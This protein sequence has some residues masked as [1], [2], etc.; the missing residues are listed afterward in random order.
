MKR[1]IFFNIV[2]FKKIKKVIKKCFKYCSNPNYIKSQKRLSTISFLIFFFKLTIIILIA[3]AIPTVLNSLNLIPTNSIS[4]YNV[5][6][7]EAFL[8][9]S[10]FIPVFEEI[11]LRLNLKI[12]KNNLLIT[13]LIVLTFLMYKQTELI[14]KIS[15]CS[16]I[17]VLLAIFYL[18][19]TKHLKYNKL[20]LVIGKFWENNFPII[21]HIFCLSF[22]FLHLLNYEQ[23]TPS[24]LILSPL[25]VLPQI[26]MGYALG[27]LRMN[28]GFSYNIAFHIIF[29][30]IFMLP[31]VN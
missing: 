17:L 5:D 11:I 10:I 14:G 8:I 18:F 6:S 3:G 25:I 7:I 16:M 20:K 26:I 27:Y 2:L 23:M 1:T 30:S 9:A 13:F 31:H 21:F 19:S 29:N 24:L 4:N 12:S 28:F 22:G 15:Y